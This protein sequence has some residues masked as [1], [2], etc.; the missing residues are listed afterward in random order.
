MRAAGGSSG[1][2][3][4]RRRARAHRPD[5]RPLSLLPRRTIACRSS[6]PARRPDSGGPSQRC[7][8]LAARRSLLGHRHRVY[9]GR[10]IWDTR[11]FLRGLARAGYRR[12]L[13]DRDPRTP[14]IGPSPPKRSP[15]R[16]SRSRRGLA[17]GAHLNTPP[18]RI[19]SRLNFK[20]CRRRSLSPV[21]P[22]VLPGGQHLIMTSPEHPLDHVR[23]ASVRL[24]ELRRSS[25]PEDAQHR[26]PR[27]ARRALLPRLCAVAVCGPSRMSFYTGRYVRSHG[28]TWMGFPMRV[29]EPTLGVSST[30]WA[31]AM[32]WSAR[33]I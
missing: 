22:S 26:P 16:P 12:P 7:H 5:P 14:H 2:A 18:S 6:R 8:G 4:A 9:P 11:G 25:A 10:G 30:R 17:G 21:T 15:E 33:R 20:P 31:C 24:S 29:G 23:P 32:C 3:G 19:R 13:C 27:R 1:G 28:S